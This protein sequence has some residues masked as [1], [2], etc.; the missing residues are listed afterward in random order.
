VIEK[1]DKRRLFLLVDRYLIDQVTPSVFYREYSNLSLLLEAGFLSTEEQKLFSELHSITSKFCDD[2]DELKKQAPGFFYTKQE[3][4]QKITTV[5]QRFL[6]CWQ[7]ISIDFGKLIFDFKHQFYFYE[8]SSSMAMDIIGCFLRSD[9]ECRIDATSFTFLQE[10]AVNDDLGDIL[11]SN[12]TY[13]E[14]DGPYIY[15]RDA[16]QDK[17]EAPVVV[18]MLRSQFVKLID[19]WQNKVCKKMPKEVVIM[20]ENGEFWIETKD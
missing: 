17:E 9:V 19:E 7:E 16:L 18:T 14:K 6:N 3:L 13:F 8:D 2:E 5:K 15:L 1:N 11:G 4:K 10:W 12:I 20:H